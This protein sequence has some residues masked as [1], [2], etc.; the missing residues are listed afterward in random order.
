MAS[1]LDLSCFFE[2]GAGIELGLV[3]ARQ[4]HHP[5]AESLEP[6]SVFTQVGPMMVCI[7]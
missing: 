3:L 6:G 1:G 5:L 2:E 4:A 7:H